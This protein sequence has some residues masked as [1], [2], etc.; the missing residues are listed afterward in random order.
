M[1]LFWLGSLWLAGI[2]LGR[3]TPLMT[4]QWLI[5]AGCALLSAILFRGLAASRVFFTAICILAFGGARYQHSQRPLKPDHVAHFNDADAKVHLTGVIARTP[6]VRDTYVGLHIDVESL[7]PTGLPRPESAAGRILLHTQ[8]LEAWAYGDRVY[9]VGYL[10]TPPSF[11]TFSYEDYLARQGIH[12]VMQNAYV[13]RMESGQGNPILQAIF[14]VRARALRLVYRLFPDPEASLLA[15]ILLGL[16]QG[17][18]PEVREAFNTTGTTHIIAISGFNITIVAGLFTALFGRW[19]GARAGAATAVLGIVTYTVLVG[20]DA[21]VVRAAI[22]AG[23]ALLAVRM[24]RQTHG[25]ASLATAAIAMTAADPLTL[26][27]VG[28]QLSF[29]ATLGL[30]LYAEPQRIWLIGRLSRWMEVK[31]AERWADPA[32]E[33]MLYTL[34][35]QVTTLPVTAYHFQRLSLV[36]LLANPL[37]LP[38]QPPV[39]VLGGLAVLAGSVWLPLGKIISWVAWP[40]VAF[41]IRAVEFFAQFPGASVPL[42]DVSL[43][44]VV[45]FYLLLFGA[46]A[47]ASRAGEDQPRLQQVLAL[48]ERLNLPAS[49]AIAGLVAA[50]G[51][52]WRLYVQQPDGRLHLSILDVGEGDAVL[53]Q[54]PTGRYVLIDGGSS[55]I[56]LSESL[57]RRLPLWDRRLDWLVLSSTRESQISGLIGSLERFRARSVLLTGEANGGASGRL[58]GDLR[59]LSTPV[60]EAAAGQTLDL[61]GGAFLEVLDAGEQGALLAVRYGRAAFILAAGAD[62]GLIDRTIRRGE[63]AGA[64]VLLLADGGY[65]A[66]NPPEWLAMVNPWLAVISVDA[67]NRRG[68]PSEATLSSLSDRVVLRTDIHGWIDLTTD[69]NMLWVETERDPRRHA[70]GGIQ[71]MPPPAE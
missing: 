11:E 19:L 53:L 18:S 42:G 65:A 56:A 44:A 26:W 43:L 51:F 8:R 30:V 27:D 13:E 23:L 64:H 45:A 71:P 59:Q 33:F 35:A 25:M 60:H 67:G 12:S 70:K 47:L 15:G 50:T 54:S 55:A 58:L 3:A 62:P 31:N 49:L 10:K 28:F 68:L 61:G 21:A 66:V 14:D 38:V 29:A 24:G 2:A 20:A 7:H 41:T 37:I 36:A 46:T 1:R 34:A 17:I 16:E 63:P 32:S 22:M 48:K 9:A 69:G 6:D 40:F 5:L 4:T 52:V 39:M 57:G